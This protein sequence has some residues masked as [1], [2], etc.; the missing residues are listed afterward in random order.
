MST[1]FQVDGGTLLAFATDGVTGFDAT[2]G[3]QAWHYRELGRTT[4]WSKV[5]GG[6][7][8]LRTKGGDGSLVVMAE[9]CS[10]RTK[11][12]GAARIRW[13]GPPRLARLR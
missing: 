10:G 12:G 1:E 7:V 9:E 13:R 5:T 11:R 6:A 2:T 3:K 8:L 4:T